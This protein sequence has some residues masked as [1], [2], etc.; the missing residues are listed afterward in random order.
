MSYSKLLIVQPEAVPSYSISLL[1]PKLTTLVFVH[2]I[3]RCGG[4]LDNG[5]T[6]SKMKG[7]ANMMYEVKSGA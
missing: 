7:G 2:Y 3:F 5:S 6:Q 1:K 4:K